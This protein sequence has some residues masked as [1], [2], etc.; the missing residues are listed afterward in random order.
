MEGDTQKLAAQASPMAARDMPAGELA[1][2]DRPL[3]AQPEPDLAPLYA[4]LAKAQGEFPEIPKNRIA[5]VRT[6]VGGEFSFKY[7][8]LSDLINST[9]KALSEN[10]L[11]QFQYPEGDICTTVI[12]H[13]S[14]AAISNGYPIHAKNEGR[15]HPAQEWAIAYAYARRYGL[16]ALLGI[17]AE[18][19]VE[20]DKPTS[21]GVNFEDPDRDGIIGVRGA[22]TEASDTPADR[23]R[24]YASAIEDQIGEAKTLKGLEGVWSRNVKVINRLQDSYAADYSNVFD[25]YAAKELELKNEAGS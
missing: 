12:A 15:M 13:E 10:G 17:A 5:K 16:S 6:K 11:A 8:D 23:A 24:S 4:A 25:V 9:R 22:K 1:K 19:T 20:G 14:G 2:V 18:E 3:L 21:A 7:S